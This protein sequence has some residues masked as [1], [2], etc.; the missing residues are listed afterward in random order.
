[1]GLLG[2]EMKKIWNPAVCA[3][4]LILGILYYYLFC[5][6][7]MRHLN[8]GPYEQAQFDLSAGWAAKYGTTMEPDEFEELE[9]ER[10]Q[11]LDAF[12]QELLADGY[13]SAA[14][15]TDWSGFVSW[16][17]AYGDEETPSP[18][19]REALRRALRWKSYNAVLYLSDFME[20]YQNAEQRF[21][22]YASAEKTE[23]SDVFL[24]KAKERCEEI[25]VSSARYGYLPSGMMSS[26]L[27]Y[28]RRLTV[29]SILSV[30]LLISPALVRDRLH[31]MRGTQWTSRKGRRLLRLQIIAASLSSV[32]LTLLNI[33]AY[34]APFLMQNTLI[35]KDFSLFSTYSFTFPWTDW[36]Y[37]TYLLILCGMVFLISV[38]VGGIAT[39]LSQFSAHYVA[40]LLKALP[41]YVCFRYLCAEILMEAPFFRYYRPVI[42]LASPPCYEWGALVALLA[43]SVLLRAVAYRRNLRLDI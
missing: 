11:Y 39:F 9:A 24:D 22:S 37:G 15:V 42:D 21:L 6:F 1:M 41:L 23:K 14:G 25:R 19:A 10:A 16:D 4:I 34:A 7:Y 20:N 30:V 43:L 18:E 36:T 8:N 27:E 31:R 17:K 2:Y 5:S 38:S 3:V 40:M 13:F 32:I 26:T 28:V 29:W 12:A 33:T 35:F